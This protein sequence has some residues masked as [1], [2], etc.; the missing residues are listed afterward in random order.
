MNKSQSDK[1]YA[2]FDADTGEIHLFAT[3]F[4]DLD[5]MEGE[6]GK[7]LGVIETNEILD[8]NLYRVLNGK[9][10]KKEEGEVEKRLRLEAEMQVKSRRNQKLAST[11][12]TTSPDSRVDHNSWAEYRQALRDITE[13]PGYPFE[14]IWPTPPS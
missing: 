14:V 6:L 4:I 10:C 12:W 7:N 11:D 8:G 1:L 9:I 13:Q 3:G 5:H 2:V